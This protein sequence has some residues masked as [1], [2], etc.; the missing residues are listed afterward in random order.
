MDE[1]VRN[2]NREYQRRFGGG[3]PT[4]H[5]GFGDAAQLAELI[6]KC[7][8]EGKPAREV[9]NFAADGEDVNY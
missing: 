4:E 9:Y 7:L 5:F 2:L 1:N 8:D 3:F 6:Q